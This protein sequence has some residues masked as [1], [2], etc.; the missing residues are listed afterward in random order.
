MANRLMV[1]YNLDGKEKHNIPLKIAFRQTIL[2]KIIIGKFIKPRNS[3][4]QLFYS[5]FSFLL[6]ILESRC[7]PCGL[8][9]YILHREKIS[10]KNYLF[11][12]SVQLRWRDS[13][14]PEK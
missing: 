8:I 13:G 10:T 5:F 6:C 11:N 1:M 4:L 12:S 2:I 3:F 14:S 9:P 7:K